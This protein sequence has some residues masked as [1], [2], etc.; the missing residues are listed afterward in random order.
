MA[1]LFCGYQAIYQ[2]VF[3]QKRY[4]TVAEIC[5]HAP[6]N[7]LSVS[8]TDRHEMRQVQRRR[9]SKTKPCSRT[10]KTI[11]ETIELEEESHDDNTTVTPLPRDQ[12]FFVDSPNRLTTLADLQCFGISRPTAVHAPATCF[13]A[14][15][16]QVSHSHAGR[17]L[18]IDSPHR[19]ENTSISLETAAE[20][21]KK[22]QEFAEG[23]RLTPKCG[24]FTDVQ[25]LFPEF[26][27]GSDDAQETLLHVERRRYMN[28]IRKSEVGSSE[29]DPLVRSWL[30]LFGHK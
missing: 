2:L 16:T 6:K 25:L 23:S 29:E 20:V 30:T 18:T 3:V 13:C 27:I 5:F 14:L 22:Q 8:K 28:R 11:L 24:G 19:G 7:F 26:F 1:L 17:T 10:L 9:H 12:D 15:E 4:K 21:I